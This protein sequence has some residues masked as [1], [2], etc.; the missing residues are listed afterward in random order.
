MT[1][2]GLN[3]YFDFKSQYIFQKFHWIATKYH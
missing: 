3:I 2:I 1:D